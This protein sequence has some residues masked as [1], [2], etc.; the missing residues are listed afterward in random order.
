MPE[1]I[2]VGGERKLRFARFWVDLF[3][4]GEFER[5]KASSSNERS[6]VALVDRPH[7]LGVKRRCVSEREEQK[8]V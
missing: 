3:L 2:Q 7:F 4:L 8:A 5:E 6:N 1:C